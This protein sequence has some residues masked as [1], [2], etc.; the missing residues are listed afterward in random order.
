MMSTSHIH[1]PAAPQRPHLP[2]VGKNL[3]SDTT[4]VQQIQ[5]YIEEF[6]YNYSGKPFLKL[7]K[8]GGA[9]HLQTAAQELIRLSLPIQCVEAVFIGCWLSKDMLLAD[10]VPLSFK[11]RFRGN[12]HRHI[13]LAVR[14]QGKWG[15]IGISRR[16][17]LMYKPVQYD[18]LVQMI[19]DYEASYVSLRLLHYA[20]IAGKYLNHLTQ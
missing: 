16:P 17:N 15:A 10:R 19:Q 8:N 3:V 13:V 14:C 4:K 7:N 11:S 1:Q 5:A 20:S 9:K 2:D 6:E 18:S 12:I